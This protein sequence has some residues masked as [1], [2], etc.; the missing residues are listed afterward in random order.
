MRSYVGSNQTSSSHRLRIYPFSCTRVHIFRTHSQPWK[1]RRSAA[2]LASVT[3]HLFLAALLCRKN[4]LVFSLD[5]S[6]A[7]AV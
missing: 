7:S 1:A 2:S 5:L 3:R 4:M 6:I